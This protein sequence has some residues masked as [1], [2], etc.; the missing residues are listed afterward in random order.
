MTCNIDGM[1]FKKG[2][3]SP[4]SPCLVCEPETSQ[5]SWSVNQGT[6]TH[7]SA[8]LS[9][10]P[11]WHLVVFSSPGTKQFLRGSSDRVWGQT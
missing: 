9:A 4:S 6:L 1:C 7:T 11:C 2:D 8:S 3:S 10:D 5:F